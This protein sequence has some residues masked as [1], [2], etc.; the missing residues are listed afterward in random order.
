ML[1]LVWIGVY[2]MWQPAREQQ[3][4]ITFADQPVIDIP[5]ANSN[6]EDPAALDST[7]NLTPD[8]QGQVGDPTDDPD[9]ESQ[10][11][12]Q[13]HVIPPEFIEHT[14]A[15]N[16]LMQTIAKQ[17]YGSIDDWAVIAKANPSID[18]RKLKPGMILRIP[19][20]KTNIQGKLVG[21]ETQ[22][23]VIASHTDPESKIIEYVVRPG[24][25]LSVI[26]QR[27]YGSSRHTRFIYES[28]RDILR[29][30]DAISVGQL[31]RLPPLPE[32][33]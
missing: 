1:V 31:L 30:M 6:D 28:N 13:V 26:S 27:I 21:D 32:E 4:L 7:L 3:P 15:Q 33:E 25:S 11:S 22:P 8:P 17:Y 20:D 9:A 14:V 19:K 12:P 23:G 10:T 29:S 5:D 24:D 18:P 2:W 16:E